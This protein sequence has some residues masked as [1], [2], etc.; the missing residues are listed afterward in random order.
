MPK[1]MG[2]NDHLVELRRS[3]IGPAILA[4]LIAVLLATSDDLISL[5]AW[6]I[7]LYENK[8]GGALSIYAPHEWYV[9]KW[10]A[11]ILLGITCAHPFLCFNLWKFV[12]PGL[13]EDEK[14]IVSKLFIAASLLLPLTVMGIVTA[15]PTIASIAVSTDRI[16]GVE[17]AIDTVAIASMA[18]SLSWISIVLILLTGLLSVVKVI[19]PP[20]D[21]RD[22]IRIRL[23]VIFG[24][25]LF[26]ILSNGYEGMR[27]IIIISVLIISENA[28]RLFP[29][30]FVQ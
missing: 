15:S 28:S 18:V 7:E 29:E 17:A 30:K 1:E 22:W 16:S 26:L 2:L 3:L 12:K 21:S 13:V 4:A 14:R 10:S 11:A 8:S 5:M 24:G 25:I 6:W 19:I 20:G 27:I 9:L 23:H